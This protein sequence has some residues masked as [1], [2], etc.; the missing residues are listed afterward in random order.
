V[1]LRGL[2]LLREADYRRLFVGQS[3]SFLG[4]GITPVALSFAVLGLHGSVSSLGLVLAAR[5]VA[6]ACLLLVGGVWADRLS[7][8]QAMLL[9][10]V[11]RAAVMGLMAVLLIAGDAEVWVLALLYAAEGVG[12]ALFNPAS[13]AVIPTVVSAERLQEANSLLRTAQSI[14]TVAGPALAGVLLAVADPGWAIAGDAASFLVSAFFLAR[15]RATPGVRQKRTKFFED[16]RVG[17]REVRRHT[18]IWACILSFGAFNLLAAPAWYVLGPVVADRSLGG[19]STWALL[20]AMMGV[21]SVV[22]G[23]L[24]MQVRPRHPLLMAQGAMGL[25]ALPLVLL[26]GP[27]ATAVIAVAAFVAGVQLTFSNTV[28]ETTLQRRIPRDSLARVASYDW[29]A[30]MTPV[31]IGFA[32]A[33][34]VS[35]AIGISATLWVAGIG[36]V[37]ISAA[38]ISVPSVRRLPWDVGTSPEIERG[39]P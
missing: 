12:T 39:R 16:L 6:L 3:V 7:P 15:V 30:A 36:I 17:W 25:F 1:R 21:G 19:S 8:R 29:F 11:M 24:A 18:W 38:L 9:A 23:L 4:D 32:L 5:G 31:P 35:G 2:E 33:S 34:P 13:T 20:A 14:G 27:A 37:I 26:A 28:W 10:D 22:G